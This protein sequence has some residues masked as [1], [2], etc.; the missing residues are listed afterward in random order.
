MSGA[1]YEYFESLSIRRQ[2]IRKVYD[3]C[4]FSFYAIIGSLFG[5]VVVLPSIYLISLAQGLLVITVNSYSYLYLSFILVVFVTT[6][7][8]QKK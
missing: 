7:K 3:D 1:I 4:Y 5:A 6:I 8:Y 2:A